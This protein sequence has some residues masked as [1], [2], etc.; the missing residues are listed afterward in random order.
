MFPH[1]YMSYYTYVGT[2]NVRAYVTVMYVSSY[3]P[4]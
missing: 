4:M 2:G 1:T 3:I